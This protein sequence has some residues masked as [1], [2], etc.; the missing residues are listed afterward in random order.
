M[1]ADRWLNIVVL[2]TILVAFCLQAL[3]ALPKLS[4]TNDEAVHLASGFS[5]W[6]T[7]D[8]RLNPEHPPL[9]KLVWRP[10]AND[11]NPLI[12]RRSLR[13]FTNHFQ[14]ALQRLDAIPT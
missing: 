1:N 6:Q 5:Y 7:R 11:A 9:A 13:L 3:L 8:F 10:A 14:A 4:A 2:V 12:L